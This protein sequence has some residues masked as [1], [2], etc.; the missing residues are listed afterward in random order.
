MTK[1]TGTKGFNYKRLA[2]EMGSLG[3]EDVN[4]L[5]EKFRKVREEYFSMKDQGA[6]P[7]EL[8]TYDEIIKDIY[9]QILHALDGDVQAT[10]D[11]LNS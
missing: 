4:S 10:T 11:L 5:L 2:Q 9:K 6:D 1:L 8:Q 7:G 3:G